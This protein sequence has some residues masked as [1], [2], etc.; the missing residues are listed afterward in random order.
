MAATPFPRSTQPDPLD[1]KRRPLS[2]RSLTQTRVPADM[3]ARIRGEFIEMRGF[4]PT[5]EQAARLFDL[6]REECDSILASLV[7]QGFLHRT[8]DGRYRL[9]EPPR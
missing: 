3:A 4:S 7:Q 8:A 6:P 2:I 9:F 5:V 1:F